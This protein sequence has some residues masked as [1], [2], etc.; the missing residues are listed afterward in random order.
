MET[1]RAK[2]ATPLPQSPHSNVLEWHFPAPYQLTLLGTSRAAWHTSFHIPQLNLLLDAGLVVNNSRPK[3]IFLTHGH[4]DHTLLTP[5]FV[6][7]G[8]PDPPDIVCPSEMADALDEYLDAKTML[9]KGGLAARGSLK[10]DEG[11]Y[12]L[13]THRTHG[14]KAGESVEVH[15]KNGW[16]ATAFACDH[17]VPCLGYVFYFTTMHIRPEYA[18]LPGPDIKALKDKGVEVTKPTSKP[19]FAFLGDTTVKTLGDTPQWLADSVSVVITECSFL[20]EEHRSQAEKTKHTIWSDL[21]PLIRRWPA[22]TFV[23]IHFS[24][25]YSSAEIRAFFQ[26]MDNPPE[27]IIVWCDGEG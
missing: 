25:R 16:S 23:L 3:H 6:K 5:A 24:M 26:Q 27:N 4:S 22:T 19:I 11:R 12:G 8:E 10:I 20:R 1:P 21:E 13:G 7:R 2:F 14:L 18:G 9:D 17:S 15:R